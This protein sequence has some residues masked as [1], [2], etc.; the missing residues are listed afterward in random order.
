MS[1]RPGGSSEEGVQAAA[2]DEARVAHER[3]ARLHVRVRHVRA[4]RADRDERVRRANQ[5]LRC[6]RGAVGLSLVEARVEGERERR[7][8]ARARAL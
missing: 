1:I 2:L 4:E 6:G 8:R 3:G 7:G 5:F